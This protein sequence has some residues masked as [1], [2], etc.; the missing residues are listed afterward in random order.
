MSTDSTTAT[1]LD[2]FER[3][4]ANRLQNGELPTVKPPDPI[5]PGDT[6]H[7]V[8]PVRFG[9]RRSDQYGH[10]V[11]TGGWLKFRGTLDVSVSWSEIARVERARRE[12]VVS[13][14]DSR[15]LLRFSCHS[16]GEAAR[17]VLLARHLSRSARSYT[18]Q[19]DTAQPY[20][21]A[22]HAAV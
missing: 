14:E 15:R 7:Y 9:R 16:E 21:P 12:I 11:L 2:T 17:G 10:L 4:F 3:E 20:T 6:C 13:L 22:N 1:D 5:A 19:P 18:A 8:V